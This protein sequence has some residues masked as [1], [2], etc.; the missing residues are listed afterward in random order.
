MV[1]T[2]TPAAPPTATLAGVDAKLRRALL[3]ANRLDQELAEFVKRKPFFARVDRETIPSGDVG[4]IV[5]VKNFSVGEPDVS[6]VLQAGEVLYQLRSTLDHLIHQLV[7]L[8]GNESRLVDSRRHQ[9][10]IFETAAGY[11]E[12]A[13]KTID[14]VSP[15][16]SATI[17]KLQP[18]ENRPDGPRNDMLWILQDLN[19]TDKHR[20]IPV[21][22]VGIDVIDVTGNAGP[23][24]LFTVQSPDIVLD[25]EKT[26]FSFKWS[27]PDNRIE[28]AISCTVAFAQAMSPYGVTLGM[29]GV[30]FGILHRVTQVV[31]TFRPRFL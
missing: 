26:L 9:F 29:D 1:T 11:D 6:L 8:S 22:V 19:N 18:F 5:G 30:L 28:A 23:G 7:I 24:K 15:D 20:L 16:I 25:H 4:R 12:R 27:V 17:R 13:A 21:A 10:P 2:L 3:T 31:D 14:G